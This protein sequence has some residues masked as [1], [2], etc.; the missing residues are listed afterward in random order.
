M[1]K[2]ISSTEKKDICFL[3]FVAINNVN[4]CLETDLENK[5]K[6]VGCSRGGRWGGQLVPE[7][8]SIVSPLQETEK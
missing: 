3:S 6:A 1:S 2:K 7:S 8:S 5:E 4:F